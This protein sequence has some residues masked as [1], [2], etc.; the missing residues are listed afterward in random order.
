M[1]SKPRMLWFVCRTSV[2]GVPQLIHSMHSQSTGWTYSSPTKAGA[3]RKWRSRMR[4]YA[5]EFLALSKVKIE[6]DDGS[7]RAAAPRTEKP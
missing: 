4:K 2:E 5:K 7:V 6:V 1:K 3:V